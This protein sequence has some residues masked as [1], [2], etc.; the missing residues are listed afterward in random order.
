MLEEWERYAPQFIKVTPVEYK[1]H[2]EK[3]Y[4]IDNKVN[5]L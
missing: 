3:E 5:N 2:L 1:H 4:I